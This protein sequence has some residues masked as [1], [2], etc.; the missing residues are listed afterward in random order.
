M[1]LGDLLARLH[2]KDNAKGKRPPHTPKY[3][4][5]RVLADGAFD[6][7]HLGCVALIKV[8]MNTGAGPTGFVGPELGDIH[9]DAEIAFIHIRA[10]RARN[11]KTRY[12]SRQSPLVGVALEAFSK[13][14]ERYLRS[15]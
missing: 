2:F 4:K 5:T 14:L 9:L 6:S 11:L 10:N 1:A 3:R 12:R 13:A 8:M 7:L 15:N